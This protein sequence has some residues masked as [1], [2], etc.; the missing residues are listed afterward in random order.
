MILKCHDPAVKLRDC[1]RLRSDLSSRGPAS[2]IT[3]PSSG[4]I[5]RSFYKEAIA[6]DRSLYRRRPGALRKGRTVVDHDLQHGTEGR[7]DMR[8]EI[9]GREDLQ[10]QVVE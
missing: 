10:G 7:V 3:L 1:E 2:Y 4:A 5:C 9:G 6:L 8:G